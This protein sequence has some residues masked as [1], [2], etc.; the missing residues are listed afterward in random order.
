MT[1]CTR[2]SPRGSRRRACGR[3]LTWA[4]AAGGWRGGCL[5]LGCAAWSSHS[6]GPR[7]SAWRPARQCRRTAPGC[8]SRTPLSTRWPRST[9][10]TTMPTRSSRSAKRGGCCGW[11]PV[12]RLRAEQG[13]RPRTGGGHPRLGRRVPVRRRGRGRARGRGFRRSRGHGVGRTLG[14]SPAHPV[15]ACRRRRVPADP[16]AKRGGC[17]GH[18]R[19]PEPSADADHARLRGLRVYASSFRRGARR[20]VT[21]PSLVLAWTSTLSA[22][23]L[24]SGASDEASSL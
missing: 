7:C 12:C 23:S 2:L 16:R 3:C 21:S 15:L 14:R 20:T 8:R 4:A 24:A 18:R 6:Y 17:G 9:R 1:T 19:H 13:Q 5:S 10:S 11:R 22:R